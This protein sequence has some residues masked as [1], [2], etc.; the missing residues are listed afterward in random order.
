[1]F[2]KFHLVSV[3]RTFLMLMMT[4]NSYYQESDLRCICQT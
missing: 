3:G 1:M 4:V 2:V